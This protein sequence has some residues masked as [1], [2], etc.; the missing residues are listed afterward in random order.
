MMFLFKFLKDSF[1]GSL[2]VFSVH[3]LLLR[4]LITNTNIQFR[5]MGFILLIYL[6]ELPLFVEL[7]F[8]GM[9]LLN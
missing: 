6:S 8:D 7:D 9:N 3:I 1:I 4:L 2:F 5:I